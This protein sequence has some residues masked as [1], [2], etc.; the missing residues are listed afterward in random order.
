MKQ[1]Y[2]MA[3]KMLVDDKRKVQFMYR[4]EPSNAQDSGWRFF[5]GEEE[6]EYVDNPNN[7]GIYDVQTI[8]KI[9]ADIV[10]YLSSATGCAYERENVNSAFARSKDF[11]WGEG[12]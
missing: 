4:E 2:V 3:T 5:C 10:P 11:T 6:E 8:S 7:I 9:D 1:G 12:R